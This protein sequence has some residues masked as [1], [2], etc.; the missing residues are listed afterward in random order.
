MEP[1]GFLTPLILDDSDPMLCQHPLMINEF[2]FTTV[3]VHWCFYESII[4]S[5]LISW[6][7]SVRKS[8][9]FPSL[10][11]SFLSFFFILYLSGWIHGLSYS[12]CHNPLPSVFSAQLSPVSR[13]SHCSTVGSSGLLKLAPEPFRFIS[14]LLWSF[15]YLLPKLDVPSSSC[16][17]PV[18]A[19][20]PSISPNCPGSFY[21]GM[22]FMSQDVCAHCY[23]GV[24]DPGPFQ[25][26]EL[27]INIHLCF[28]IFTLWA[29]TFTSN[30]S[31]T[32]QAAFSSSPSHI[33]TSQAE[34][35]NTPTSINVFAHLLHAMV[36]AKQLR[37]W[38]ATGNPIK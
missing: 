28:N 7:S 2:I 29:H 18:S 17:F 14:V 12:V 10:S 33:W 4:P 25:Q 3:V 16:I 31:P 23:R 36:T 20:E 5:S 22:I 32:S 26:K 6:H 11:P 37:T 13:C 30:S 24:I 1:N 8:F 27:E 9:P 21:W 34:N 38:W 35:P 19:L 15:P